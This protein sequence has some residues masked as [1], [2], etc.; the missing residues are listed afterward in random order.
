MPRLFGTNGIR[1][2]VNEDMNIEL[3]SGIGRAVGSFLGG[4][5]K[6]VVGTDTRTSNEML[7]DALVSGLLSTGCDTIDVGISPSPAIQ[8]AVKNG[9]G[10]FGV[11][12]TA[13]HNPPQFNGIK[14]ID[15]D[16]TE[17]AREKEE[18]IEKIYFEKSFVVKPWNE[19]GRCL[20]NPKANQNYIEGI[21]G[22]CEVELIRKAKLKVLLDC[23]NGAA[24]FTSPYLFEM[25]GCHVISLNSHPQGTFPGHASEPTPD[26]L[27]DT[28][29]IASALGADLTVV[30]DGDADRTIFIDEK[31]QYIHG[32]RSLALIARETVKARNGGLVVTPVA[33][34]LCLEDAVKSYGG[35]V[36][37]TRVG[38]PIV[39]RAMIE[40]NAVFG[41]EENGGMIFPEFQYCRDG[42][43]AA[44]RMIEILARTGLKLSE[45]IDSLPKYAQVKTKVEC[46]EAKK[47]AALRK[48]V[49]H[50]KGEK[51]DTT[52]G[53]KIMFEKAWVLVRPSGTEP[54]YRVYAEAETMEKAKKLSDENKKLIEEIIRSL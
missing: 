9:F 53:V 43:M 40:H 2:V 29:K 17:L 13:S 24:S 35:R 21:I 45:L 27:K 19:I 1:G 12:I 25:L 11:I 41:G 30:H 36:L 46:P 18:A 4:K 5:G 32:D 38:A 39:A 31:G 34:S 6:V 33:T 49:E 52:D 28:I 20:S 51:I 47:E 42:G 8:Y 37:Y 26:N 7:K 54:I 23:S 16:G 3:A 44:A 22:K 10:N 48:L 50:Y 15:A 14:C